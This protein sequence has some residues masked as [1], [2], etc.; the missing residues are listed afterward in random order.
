ML[1]PRVAAAVGRTLK[2]PTTPPE[3]LGRGHQ[4]E[5]DAQGPLL[6][7]V[8][9][10]GPDQDQAGQALQDGQAFQRIADQVPHGA[11]PSHREI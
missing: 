1:V 6:P 11:A 3:Y 10:S 9:N 5:S 7:V 4:T 8:P 2:E